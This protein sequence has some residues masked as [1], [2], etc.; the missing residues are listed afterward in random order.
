MSHLIFIP[1]SH[2]DGLLG[3]WWKRYAETPPE[4]EDDDHEPAEVDSEQA[5]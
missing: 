4:P 1:D 5:R 3:S 2:R